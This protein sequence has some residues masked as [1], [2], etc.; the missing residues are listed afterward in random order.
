[1][2]G[3][4]RRKVRGLRAIERRVLEAHRPAAAPEPTPPDERSKTD[5]P[6]LAGASEAAAPCAS[7]DLG[8]PTT[9]SALAATGVATTGEA[10]VEGEAGRRVFGGLAGGGGGV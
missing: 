9:D 1:A 4:L 3:K 6:P 2:K 8:L 10:L 7:S 5:A